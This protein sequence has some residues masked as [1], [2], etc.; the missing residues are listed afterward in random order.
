MNNKKITFKEIA[1][2]AGLSVASV[3]RAI[4]KPHLTSSKTQERVNLAIKQLNYHT[5]NAFKAPTE[6]NQSK[7]LLVI[8]NQLFSN[9][10]IN[11][12]IDSKAKQLGYKL[13]YLR[14][15]HFS[16]HE[17]Q[18]MISYTINHRVDGILLINDS[19]YLDQLLPFS[20]ALPPIVLVNNFSV[21]FP[22]VYFDHLSLAYQAT[23]HLLSIGHKKIGIVLSNSNKLSNF[24][25]EQGYLQALSR[26]D[27]LV[28]KRYIIHNCG[29]YRQAKSAIKQLFNQPNPPSAL[30]CT[31][32]LCLNYMDE[33][34]SFSSA[35]ITS[36]NEM[37]YGVLNQCRDLRLNLPKQL[38]VLYFSHHKTNMLHHELNH[39]STLYKP[40]FL[41]GEQSVELLLTILQPNDYAEKFKL[42]EGEL[43][44]RHSILQIPYYDQ[45]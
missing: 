34:K 21:E 37:I 40:L 35:T 12:G 2:A 13:L 20:H 14:F 3:S 26:Y 28:D 1:Q 32:N 23:E 33:D 27:V 11:K 9:S 15:L 10:L 18:Q 42:I 25:L 19:P 39:F 24:Y 36:S 45:G 44:V 43:I 31:D 38:S 6:R 7:K 8:D 5:K 22:C 29:R 16:E 41:M 17:I 30:V 4:H